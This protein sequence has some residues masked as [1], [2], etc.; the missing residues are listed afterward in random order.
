M[1]DIPTQGWPAA[2]DVGTSSQHGNPEHSNPEHNHLEHSDPT[3]T[4]E[5]LRRLWLAGARDI[6][7]TYDEQAVRHRA[8]L[9]RPRADAQ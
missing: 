6:T 5:H 4:T 9:L 7:V 8:Y 2:N 1:S 3:A